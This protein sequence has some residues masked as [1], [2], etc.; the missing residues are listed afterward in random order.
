MPNGGHVPPSNHIPANTVVNGPVSVHPGYHG[1]DPNY[2]SPPRLSQTMPPAPSPNYPGQNVPA[3]QSS[4]RMKMSEPPPPPPP[5]PSPGHQQ[6]RESFVN[7]QRPSSTRIGMPPPPPPPLTEMSSSPR[8]PMTS[9]PSSGDLPP[10]PPPP[11][12][13]PQDSP[14]PPSPP[15]VLQHTSPAPPPPPP[16]PPPPAPLQP[17][18]NISVS[19]D[20]STLSRETGT[21]VEPQ[22]PAQPKQTARSALLEEIRLGKSLLMSDSVVNL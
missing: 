4:Q 9:Y 22:A 14:Q 10:P 5:Q 2:S 20:N 13:E 1:H 19:S 18:D 16:P 21:S 6:Q 3:Y 12:P 11:L 15:P 17:A 8:Q 7:S